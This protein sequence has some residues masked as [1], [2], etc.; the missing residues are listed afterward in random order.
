MMVIVMGLMAR[1]MIKKT[2]YQDYGMRQHNPKLGRFF[3][4]DPLIIQ[5][6]Q[7]LY[8]SPYQFAGNNPIAFVDL[9]GLEPAQYIP[10]G[11]GTFITG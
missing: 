11:D 6:Q 2:G 1:K 5:G 8:L 4:A 9:D 10:N 7:Y 3:S